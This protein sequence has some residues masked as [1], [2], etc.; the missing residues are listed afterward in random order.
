M[1]QVVCLTMLAFVIYSGTGSSQTPQDTYQQ[2]TPVSVRVTA[3]SSGVSG[4]IAR[5][6]VMR[7]VCR[8][9]T[10]GGSGF[11]HRS[12]R[13]ITA[14]HVVSDCPPAARLL[15]LSNGQRTTVS[16]AQMDF[17]RDLAILT[18]HEAITGPTLALS[19]QS[20]IPIGT[21]LTA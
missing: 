3:E 18:P 14:E 2:T 8:S 7:V 9:T 20:Q 4:T 10:F 21:Q 16:L 12:G 11:L 6:S 1:F 15:I 17:E 5:G 19:T 13:V